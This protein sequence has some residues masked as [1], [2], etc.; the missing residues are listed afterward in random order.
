MHTLPPFGITRPEDARNRFSVSPIA[1]FTSSYALRARA[2][3]GS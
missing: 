2:R 1:C 3:L